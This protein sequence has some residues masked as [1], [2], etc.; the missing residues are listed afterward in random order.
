MQSQNQLHIHPGDF[1]EST[2]RQS[3]CYVTRRMREEHCVTRLLLRLYGNGYEGTEYD[4]NLSVSL[5]EI[6]ELMEFER[7]SL[8]EVRESVAYRIA[9]WEVPGATLP[10]IQDA[11]PVG[12]YFGAAGKFKDLDGRDIVFRPSAGHQAIAAF[13]PSKGGTKFV[14]GL[15]RTRSSTYQ[16]TE[17]AILRQLCHIVGGAVLQQRTQE[18]YLVFERQLELAERKARQIQFAASVVHEI[19][20]PLTAIQCNIE[21]VRRLLKSGRYSTQEGSQVLDETAAQIEEVTAVMTKIRALFSNE[22]LQLVPLSLRS[23]VKSAVRR[24]ERL[25]GR[26][27]IKYEFGQPET[28]VLGE[29]L[30]LRQVVANLLRNAID[31]TD[32]CSVPAIKIEISALDDQWVR[33]TLADNGSGI[34]AAKMQSIFEPFDS[35]KSGG[36][37]M[38]L[39]LCRE[40]VIRHGGRIEAG[41][42]SG[43]GALFNVT[44][45][46][47]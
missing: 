23:I 1:A 12:H 13:V 40:I 44:L 15:E 33:L 47:A 38:G 18:Q 31:A 3:D 29:A 43:G 35:S 11:Y 32:S 27:K 10:L 7:C 45:P 37:G 19:S 30:Q 9:H 20:Q 24:E 28:K 17:V 36:M 21:A 5:R 25:I 42:S 14:L 39:A 34:P 16:H 41:N 46:R 4:D 6:A 8:W 2:D 26:G 22:P